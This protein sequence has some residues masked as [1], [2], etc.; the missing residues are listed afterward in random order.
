[1][2]INL[3]LLL[4]NHLLKSQW[5]D[6]LQLPVRL[7][8]PLLDST[9]SNS[10]TRVPLTAASQRLISNQLLSNLSSPCIHSDRLNFPG[11]DLISLHIGQGT[12]LCSAL[13][14]SRS[15][16]GWMRS[17]WNPATSRLVTECCSEPWELFTSLQSVMWK[18]LCYIWWDLQPSPSLSPCPKLM[19]K[20]M[21]AQPGCSHTS[22][23]AEIHQP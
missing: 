10:H 7:P 8:V 22:R 16:I 14:K 1:M 17:S 2:K 20:H 23:S 9:S 11:S 21:A 13:G 15:I 18:E 12:T 6:Y 4:Q 19:P 5:R 3:L